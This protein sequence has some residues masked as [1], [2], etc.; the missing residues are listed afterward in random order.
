[1]NCIVFFIKRP[2]SVVMAIAAV[3]IGGVFSL[4]RLPLEK[5]PEISYP[6]VTVETEYAGLGA[7]EV[8]SIITIPVEDALSS[9]KG[10]E[11]M[12]SVSRDGSSLVTLDFRWGTDPGAASALAR[13]AIDTVYPNLPQGV[14]K[15]SVTIGDPDV[16][17][18]AIVAV[19]ILNRDGG[20]DRSIAEYD[21]RSR[22]RRID[23]VG[24]VMLSGGAA[25][26]MRVALDVQKAVAM[27][28]D[29]TRLAETLSRDAADVPAG[30]V[31]DADK[32]TVVV[33]GGRPVSIEELSNLI[34]PSSNGFF[35]LSDIAKITKEDARKKSLFI[36]NGKEYV[37]LAIYRR[38]MADPLRLSRDI[39]KTVA[40]AA[41]DFPGTEILL[42][43][44]AS[45][46][47]A[48]SVRNLLF[49]ALLGAA[50][51]T[52]TLFS[53]LKRFRISFLAV[54]SI[55]LSIAAGLCVLSLFG[56]SLNGMS[57]SGLAL[58]IG[59]APDTPVIALDLLHRTFSGVHARADKP[60]AEAVGVCVSQISLSCLAGTVTT[61]IVFV[62]IVFLPGPLGALFGD[63][64]IA[65]VASIASSWIYA[66][67]L[68]PSLYRMMWKSERLAG[69][70]TMTGSCGRFYQ[71]N[72][73]RSL[74]NPA[75]VFGAAFLLCVVG[76]ALLLRMPAAF[77]SAD[78]ASEIQ[79]TIDF[80]SA[81]RLEAMA[82]QSAVIAEAL[83]A[84]DGISGVFGGAGAEDDDTGKR[85][86]M[87]YRKERLVFRCPL[88]KGA[89]L[90][91]T[92]FHARTLADRFSD[93]TVTI[94]VDIPQDKTEKLLGL[95]SSRLWMVQGADHKESVERAGRIVER[96]ERLEDNECK[97]ALVNTYTRPEIR[98]TPNREAAAG[99][100]TS[101]FGIAQALY[102]ATEGM[103][104]ISI[105]IEG[106]S[107]DVRVDTEQIGR[108]S[109]ETL[110]FEAALKNMPV[111]RVNSGIVFLGSV[112]H[113]EKREAE[114]QLTRLDRADTVYFEVYDE[115]GDA[116]AL[117]NAEG[118]VKAGESIFT[119]YRASLVVIVLLVLF[120]LYMVMAAQ[121]ESFILPVVI[122]L[123]IPFSFAGVGPGLFLTHSLFDSGAALGMVTLFGLVVNNGI[124]LYE[125][126][127]EKMRKTANLAAAVFGGSCDRF[128][129]ILITTLNTVFS[130][131]PP[132]IT[133][134][135]FSQKSIASAMLGGVIA[136]TLLSLFALPP[137]LS[138]FLKKR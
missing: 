22:F 63:L 4:S 9:V 17:A 18:H 120:L 51:V 40:E 129:P 39:K 97:I 80:P 96:A 32:E 70:R 116:S 57:L 6:K 37:S 29:P 93:E 5:R 94:T 103:V 24:A 64:S 100:G 42:L 127:I 36:Y 123:S 86:A 104:P 92:L 133:P 20:L 25:Q 27:G 102:A 117:L 113:I 87:D 119:Q 138:R 46:S 61:A 125:I 7:E 98:I 112:A 84:L 8:R 53:F 35:R 28:L 77:V 89:K 71:K 130:L 65:L 21:I 136:S 78:N 54:F 60:D 75:A 82:G 91:E 56:R 99:I 107:L 79:V 110:A 44:E 90:N 16:E 34:L 72:L 109:G 58:G 10:L 59:L 121:F 126:S 67:F 23:G 137:V 76:I 12:R 13:E 1:M 52:I 73:K 105:E 128:R 101:S 66:Q 88:K 26:E 33:S 115:K 45:S 114:A 124:V 11:R 74:R 135:A 55:P 47:I 83:S 3:F 69:R 50:A 85:A 48:D 68:L 62:P 108:S 19:R 81:T 132:A 30:S 15:P 43:Y 38:N 111:A 31:R 95:S 131:L 134:L 118:A 41:A 106:K 122:M 14:N 2:V 49:S